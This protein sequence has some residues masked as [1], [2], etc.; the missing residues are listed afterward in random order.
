MHIDE[1]IR[2]SRAQSCPH[3]ICN[4]HYR[5]HW[6]FIGHWW[7]CRY[8]D[9][10]VKKH[11]CARLL[12]LV[13]VASPVSRLVEHIITLHFALGLKAGDKIVSSAIDVRRKSWPSERIEELI[14]SLI[15]CIHVTIQ[16]LL[17]RSSLMII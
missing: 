14:F 7:I 11:K 4:L 3:L 15:E 8:P 17:L 13:K 9:E 12:R 1:L 10:K 6:R 5:A 16:S 2:P